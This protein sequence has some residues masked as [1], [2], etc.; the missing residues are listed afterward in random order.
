V[1]CCGHQ[2]YEHK[3]PEYREMCSGDPEACHAQAAIGEALRRLISMT[4]ASTKQWTPYL[5]TFAF[6]FAMAASCNTG[7]IRSQPS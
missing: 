7:A 4:L 1:P 5:R 6:L 2:G 3:K